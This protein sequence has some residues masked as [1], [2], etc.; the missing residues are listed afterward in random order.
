MAK[1][2]KDHKVSSTT[3]SPSPR[4]TDMSSGLFV[5]HKQ[6]GLKIRGYRESNKWLQ[7]DLADSSGLPVRTIGRIERAEVDV[8]LSTLYKVARSLGIRLEDLLL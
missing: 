3:K 5:V 4:K 6:I 7:S 8:R 2:R 1:A